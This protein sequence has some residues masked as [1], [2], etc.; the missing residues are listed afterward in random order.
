MEKVLVIVPTYNEKDNIQKL[1]SQVL[2]V[3]PE[4]EML[5]VDD[6]SPDGTGRWCDTRSSVDARLRC[7]HRPDKLGLGTA[8]IAALRYAVEHDYTY[9]VNMDADHS[10]DP[11]VIPQM[12]A[13]MDPA[14]QPPVDV[15]IG[16]RYVPGGAIEGWTVWRHMMSR[17]VNFYARWVLW[18]DCRDCSGAFRCYR[19]AV[20]KQLDFGAFKAQGY[21]FLEEL[22]WHLKRHGCRFVEIPIVFANRKLGSSKINSREAL[23][24]LWTIFRLGLASWLGR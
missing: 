18:L 11:R 10:H 6:N 8:T 22:L 12:V 23:A 17:A 20:L 14:D 16:S 7:L 13:A 2:A 24:A 1:I 5:I 19:V 3:S 15:V 21:A 4:I 9:V